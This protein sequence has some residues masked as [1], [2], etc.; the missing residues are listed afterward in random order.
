[1]CRTV[2]QEDDHQEYP[3]TGPSHTYV[4]DDEFEERCG[5]SCG[6]VVT[7][8]M[9]CDI[10]CRTTEDILIQTL[11]TLGFA[12]TYDLLYLPLKQRS[13]QHR[14]NLGY[15]FVNFKLPQDA[16]RFA[17]TFVNFAFPNTQSKK[18]SY[19]KPAACQGF[20]AHASMQ[21]ASKRSQ[22]RQQASPLSG[23]V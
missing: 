22:Y 20:V 7:T 4:T 12:G 9:L 2:Q 8:L 14:G 21:S 11:A 5:M 23:L 13:S 6:Q 15:A 10:P 1:M 16:S 17:A 19:A 18:L 3:L